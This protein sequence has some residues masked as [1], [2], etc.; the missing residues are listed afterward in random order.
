MYNIEV[1]RAERKQLLTET[2]NLCDLVPLFAVMIANWM[3]SAHACQ[4][5]VS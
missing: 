4:R 5:L 1:L 2:Q 3:A